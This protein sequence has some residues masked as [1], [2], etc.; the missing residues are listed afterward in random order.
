ML[1]H[2]RLL[3]ATHLLV[4]P[5]RPAATAS[6]LLCGRTWQRRKDS[7]RQASQQPVAEQLVHQLQEGLQWPQCARQLQR[8]TKV[9]HLQEAQASEFKVSLRMSHAHV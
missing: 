3:R 2:I 7:C 6:L 8:R 5:A 9:S 4:V 1:L